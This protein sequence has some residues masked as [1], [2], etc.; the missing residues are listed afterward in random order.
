MRV[1]QEA[2]RD[3]LGK[4]AIQLVIPVY[5]RVYAWSQR[6][7]DDLWSDIMRAGRTGASRFMGT[8]LYAIE[9]GTDRIGEAGQRLDVIDGQQRLATITLLLCALRDWLAEGDTASNIDAQAIDQRYLHASG[10]DRT[11]K[12]LL[13]RTDQ[14]TLAALIDRTPLPADDD[15]SP[16]V[17]SNY[18]RFRTKMANGFDSDDAEALWHGL[19][20]LLM[21]GAQMDD[22]DRPQLVFESLNSKGMPLTTADLVRNL[23]LVGVSYAEQA[24]LYEQYWAP[25]EDLLGAADTGEE[26]AEGGAGTNA[27]TEAEASSSDAA[28]V[29]AL[30]GWLALRA[31][32]LPVGGSD[33]VY[34]AFKAFL[35]TRWEGA[36]EEL[37]SDL[38]DFCQ[39]FA[40]TTLRG[41]NLRAARARTGGGAIAAAHGRSLEG[42][43]TGLIADKRLFGD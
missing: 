9:P 12:L 37:L 43:P 16:N 33:G 8:V 31:P 26:G 14:P 39:K 21:V 42:G 2:L 1:H 40:T 10:P 34:P 13:S 3:F 18:E 17:A 4:P 19:G 41:Y 15:A 6:Q 29:A 5:Q 7:C 32:G 11:P 20:L 30:H 28:L 27:R 36:P 22:Q 35:E 38:H 25:I 24:R 23:L